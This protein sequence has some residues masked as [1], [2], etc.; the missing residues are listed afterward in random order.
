MPKKERAITDEHMDHDE[1]KYITNHLQIRQHK[2]LEFIC[3]CEVKLNFLLKNKERKKEKKC[4]YPF[5]LTHKTNA[6]NLLNI[7]DEF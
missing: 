1:K 2:Y 6:V 5:L 3:E 7:K 4:F